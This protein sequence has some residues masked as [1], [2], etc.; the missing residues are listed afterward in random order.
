MRIGLLGPARGDTEATREA[1]EFLLGDAEVDQAIYLGDDPEALDELLQKWASEVFGE[2]YD[3]DAFLRRAAEVA[4]RGDAVAIEG[5]LHRD[6]WVRKLGRI[7]NLPPSPARAVEMIGD[8]ILLAVHDKAVLDEEDIANAQLI[9]YGRANE[10]ELRRFGSRYFLTPGPLDAGQV[11]ILETEGP[12]DV[13]VAL[14][15]T[16]GVPV[17]RQT[18]ARRTGKVNVV[19]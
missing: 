13:V 4:E 1:I 7:R 10:A 3:D 9:V 5:L 14:Y 16:T 8:R 17:S 11:A 6:A 15:E 19:R 18:L 2:A 12:N